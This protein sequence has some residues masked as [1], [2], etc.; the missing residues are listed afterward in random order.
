MTTTS[1]PRL[2]RDPSGVSKLDRFFEISARGSDVATEVRGGLATFATMAYI[3]VLNPII[4]TAAAD[5]NG[6]TLDF[7]QVAVMTC[8]AAAVSTFFMGVIARHP[9]AIAAGLGLNS[10]LAVQVASI[11]AIAP[12]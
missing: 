2:S 1:Q 3:I 12:G 11:T 4:L 10:F 8:L 9:F 5:V 6:M 7:T